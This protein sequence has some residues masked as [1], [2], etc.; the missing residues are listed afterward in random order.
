MADPRTKHASGVRT[1]IR[2]LS[3]APGCEL[4]VAAIPDESAADR[5]PREQA[6]LVYSSVARALEAEDARVFS[7]RVF[8]S[9]ETIDEVRAARAEVFGGFDDGVEPTSLLLPPSVGSGPGTPAV[10]GVQVHAMRT[11]AELE[12]LTDG[13]GPV[14]RRVTQGEH[15]WV[16]LGAVDD[17]R[18]G[19]PRERAQRMF[20]TA[21]ERLALAGCGFDEVARTWL[22]LGDICDW[23][24]DLNAARTAF[25]E[26]IG[27]RESFPA[28]TGIGIRPAGADALCAM[29]LIAIKGPEGTVRQHQAD[30][31]QE[32]AFC[33][34]SAF[35]RASTAITPGGTTVF[36]SGTAAIDHAGE[37]E[38]PGL[39]KPQIDATLAHVRAVLSAHGCGD[40]DLLST[41]AY[42]KDEAVLR[43]FEQTEMGRAWP[44]MAVIADVCRPELTFE[45]EVT[46]ARE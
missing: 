43:E 1:H 6:E 42:C 21:A 46:A 24:P 36:V 38:F 11:P 44:G 30:G 8:A 40:K 28:S 14:G 13:T 39:I 2:K 15:G 9:E 34:G 7:E 19:T 20:D 4:H 5:S 35:A 32:P 3:S 22:W 31:E 25:F 26:R 41:L 29:D 27:L 18:R 37:T 45:I 23:Y 10:F 33:Y 16:F 17:G 12:V